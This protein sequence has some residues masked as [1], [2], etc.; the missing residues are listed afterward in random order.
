MKYDRTHMS[1]HGVIY[2]GLTH[3]KE[4]VQVHGFTWIDNLIF[5]AVQCFK[6]HGGIVKRPDPEPIPYQS[7]T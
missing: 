3:K 5:R 1:V 6:D 7:P 4:S 2:L